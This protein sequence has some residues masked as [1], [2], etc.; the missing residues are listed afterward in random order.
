AAGLHGR[1]NTYT[2]HDT[3]EVLHKG[4]PGVA[5][6]GTCVGSRC[7]TAGLTEAVNAEGLCGFDD[8]RLPDQR[9]IA[10]LNDPASA[11]PG[12]TVYAQH[13][14]TLLAEQ[15]WT[16]DSHLYY[17]GAW[18]W[19]FRYGHNQVDWKHTAK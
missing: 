14:P 4:D 3:D 12:P 18:A 8:W 16:R 2:W 5:D 6:G 19:N 9:E 11:A 13:F 15:Y 1:D 10:T 17:P 7:D